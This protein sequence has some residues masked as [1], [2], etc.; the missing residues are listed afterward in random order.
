M[1]AN[2]NAN[3]TNPLPFWFF[4]ELLAA[5]QDIKPVPT[6]ERRSSG[7]SQESKTFKRWID[8]LRESPLPAGTG[9][10][11]FRLFFPEEGV[12]RRY[13]RLWYAKHQLLIVS[14]YGLKEQ[15]LCGKLAKYF[16]ERSSTFDGWCSATLEQRSLSLGCLGAEVVRLLPEDYLP[17]RQGTLTLGRQVRSCFE[18]ETQADFSSSQS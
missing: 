8:K 12:R 9:V 2:A 3:Y 14:R 11:F 6:G 13:A 15:T 5:I 1:A 7:K 18:P 17:R 16:K 4:C 10:I